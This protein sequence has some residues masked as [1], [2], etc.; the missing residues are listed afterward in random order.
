M[1]HTEDL[2]DLLKQRLKKLQVLQKKGKTTFAYSFKDKQDIG[3]VTSKYFKLEA[4]QEGEKAKIGGRIVAFRQ[5]GKA[6]FA[7]VADSSGKIQ[8]YFAADVL[9]K[10][11]E[12]LSE[13][14]I[15]DIAGFEGLVFKTRRGELSLKVE[16]YQLL[17]KSLRPLPEKWHGLKDVET[18][19]RQRYLDLI[20]NPRA[21]EIFSIREKALRTIRNFLNDKGFAEVDTP[22]LQPLYGGATARPFVTHHNA[23]DRDLYLRI[24][25][26]LYLKRLLIGNMEKVFELG[27][28]FRNEGL[29]IKHNPEFTMLEVY[30]AYADYNDMMDL[31]EKLIK[32]MVNVASGSL[33]ITYQDKEIDFSKFE[34]ISMIESIEKLGKVKV[35]FDMNVAELKKIAKNNEIKLQD[36][37]GKGH[38]INAIF[39]KLVEP[40]LIQP[41][42]VTDFPVEV[43]P[44]ARTNQKDENLAERFELI[45]FA[46]EVANAFSELTNPIEQRKRFEEQIKTEARDEVPQVIDE[47]FIKALEYGMPPAGGLG[48]GIDRLL[49]IL[50]DSY[51]IKEV[52][53]F[54]HLRTFE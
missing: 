3:S 10:R 15:G 52:I 27:R 5:H 7:D 37:W 2:S 16:K 9:G 33:K 19:F 44:L 30:Q 45:V 18:R 25:P 42:F 20:A 28:N 32:E 40:Q 22:I 46:R 4:S 51:S 1:P 36:F 41:T 54:P 50:T 53:L 43:S 38:I 29:S 8:L 13:L 31:T 47:D 24:A 14:D 34:K 49:M 26:E 12:E 6:T 35:S 23:L 17:T 21:R 39:E 11:Y 48:V